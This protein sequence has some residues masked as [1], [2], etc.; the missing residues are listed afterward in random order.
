M[1]HAT[2]HTLTADEGQCYLTS[3]ISSGMEDIQVN[4]KTYR[5]ILCFSAV[6]VSETL[7]K[8]STEPKRTEELLLAVHVIR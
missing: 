7:G 5:A 4:F 6:S 8:Q 1:Q 2:R 3:Q